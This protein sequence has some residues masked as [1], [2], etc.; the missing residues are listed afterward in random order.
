MVGE[1]QILTSGIG[2]ITGAKVKKDS[3]VFYANAREPGT[4]S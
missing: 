3:L 4:A 1:I 2:I